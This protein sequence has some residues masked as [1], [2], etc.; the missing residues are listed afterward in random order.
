MSRPSQNPEHA[1]FSFLLTMPKKIITWSNRNHW[2]WVFAIAPFALIFIPI[3]LTDLEI[4]K[5]TDGWFAGLVVMVL[6]ISLV[7]MIR[8]FFLERVHRRFAPTL[9]EKADQHGLALPIGFGGIILLGWISDV[10]GLPKSLA[11]LI[12]FALYSIWLWFALVRE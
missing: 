6:L 2:F 3:T 9:T 4:V 11:G 12:W 7:G 5:I 10:T 8:I 1:Y